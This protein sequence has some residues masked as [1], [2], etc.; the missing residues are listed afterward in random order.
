M[1]L[2]HE[3][4]ESVERICFQVEEA[5]W[6]YEDFV[7]PLDP[8]LPSLNLRQFCLKIFQHC[9]LFSSYDSAIHS[10]AFSE[11]LAYKTRVPVRGAIMLNEAMDEVVLVKGWKKGAS[12]SFPRGKI[13]KNEKDI[14]CAIREVYEE[15]GFDIRAA[16]IVNNDVDVKFIEVTMREQ[17]MKLFI[18]THIPMN[19]EFEPRTRKEISKIQ[20]YK[21]SDLPTLKKVKQQ[22]VAEG[23][24]LG[25]T[26]KFYMVA[27]FLNPLKKIISQL[28]KQNFANT[29]AQVAPSTFPETLPTPEFYQEAIPNE[30]LENDINRLTAQLRQSKQASRES[31]LPEVSNPEE[32]AR[33]VSVYLKSLLNL[34][35]NPP[36]I[37]SSI[38]LDGTAKLENKKLA[39]LSLLRS[40][41]SEAQ[42]QSSRAIVPPRTPFEQIFVQ[43]S[44]PSPSPKHDA[45]HESRTPGLP[46]PVFPLSL[47]QYKVQIPTRSTQANRAIQSTQLPYAQPYQSFQQPQPHHQPQR[48]QQNPQ[49]TWP[50]HTTA[51]Y[52]RVDDPLSAQTPNPPGSTASFIIPPASKLPP[53]RLNAHSSALLNLFKNPSVA[54]TAHETNAALSPQQEIRLEL[55]ATTP[56]TSQKIQHPFFVGPSIP[57]LSSTPALASPFINPVSEEAQTRLQKQETLLSLFRSSPAPAKPSPSL[58]PPSDPVELSAQQSPTHTKV[59]SAAA[60]KKGNDLANI[61]VNGKVTIQ[62]RPNRTSTLNQP[63]VSATVSGPLNVPQFEKILRKETSDPKIKLEPFETEKH[64]GQGH[65]SRPIKILSRP[66]T[67]NKSNQD[68]EAAKPQSPKPKASPRRHKNNLPKEPPKSF[69]PQILKRPVEGSPQQEHQ[70]L[71]MPTFLTS[72]NGLADSTLADRRTSQTQ[73]QKAALL[74][75]FGTAH[76]VI[77]PL[78]NLGGT[79]VSPLS[80]KPAAGSAL[81]SPLGV[82]SRSR[83]GSLNS[84][85]L[86]ELSTERHTPKAT[87]SPVDK[88]FLLGFLEEVAKEGRK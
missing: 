53:P 50:V 39:M 17:H 16:G 27:P 51:P 52:Q 85:G 45:P 59:P 15:T 20:W 7:R 79:V 44:K 62:K 43:P 71:A 47:S 11:F 42:P 72:S 14:D 82:S 48:L 57:P 76:P 65:S 24:D 36:N 87:T 2:P 61:L 32:T 30:P 33:D 60:K 37:S 83:I 10:Q 6:F 55:S 13:N 22:Q 86:N 69:Q 63:S 29:K 64:N 68:F 34:P 80:E 8:K 54:D 75:L 31:N 9:P 81:P 88:K 12:W 74:S 5:Q 46:P 4:L 23:Q 70:P 38:D 40:G 1:N 66:S 67:A 18:F 25:K 49:F 19:T 41:S 73:E 21:L 78:P 77:S 56:S 3:E 28:K 26:N 84:M 35:V 58:A